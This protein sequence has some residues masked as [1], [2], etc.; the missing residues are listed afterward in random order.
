MKFTQFIVLLILASLVAAFFISCTNEGDQLPEFYVLFYVDGERFVFDMGHSDY[1]N[2]AFASQI[3]QDPDDYIT[4]IYA[5]PENLAGKLWSESTYIEVQAHGTTTGTYIDSDHVQYLVS[6]TP[7]LIQE[8]T[9]TI[10]EYG[11]VGGIIAGTFSS[12]S[13]SL[14][15]SDGEFRVVRA[16]DGSSISFPP[17]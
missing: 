10:S 14:L 12:T 15:I 5:A 6:G 1:E 7:N 13:G 9:I 2:S 8:C 4:R 3:E 16:A 17:E 11:D